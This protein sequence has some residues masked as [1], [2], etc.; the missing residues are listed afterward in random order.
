LFTGKKRLQNTFSV[1]N[2]FKVM[3]KGFDNLKPCL[4]NLIL[5]TMTILMYMA[6]VT[7]T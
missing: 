4:G 1:K 5:K 7:Y 3:N 6:G 2:C